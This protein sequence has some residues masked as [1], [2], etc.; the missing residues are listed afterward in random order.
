MAYE[1]LIVATKYKKVQERLLEK[2]ELT[3]DEAI[4]IARTY[5]ATV[6]Q[7]EQL[8]GKN[9]KDINGIKGN[10]I[11]NDN[12]AKKCP[13]C[14]LRHL[15]QPGSKCP[16]YVSVCLNCQKEN[17]WARVCSSRTQG[18]TRGRQ[19]NR[20]NNRSRHHSRR[21]DRCSSQ[22]S[23]SRKRK[24]GSQKELSNQFET[25]TFES[26]AVDVIGPQA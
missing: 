4:D 20:E 11:D 17:H 16:P 6:T 8:E 14:G 21:K 7:V 19:R 2:G 9:N 10:E 23:T 22:R 25:I 18:G 26:I 5:K 15:P 24:Y 3:L 12:K 13:N 1:Q